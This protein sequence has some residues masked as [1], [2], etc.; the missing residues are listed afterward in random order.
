M[1]KKLLTALLLSVVPLTASANTWITDPGFQ[2]V[3]PSKDAGQS[4]QIQF[5]GITTF[6][7][8]TLSFMGIQANG[9]TTDWKDVFCSAGCDN[10]SLTYSPPDGTQFVF[11]LV[12]DGNIYYAGIEGF[13]GSAGATFDYDNTGRTLISFGTPLVYNDF[14]FT[15]R[16]VQQGALMPLSS[17]PEPETYAMLLAGLA[18][19][20]SVARRRKQ[21]MK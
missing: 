17:V 10:K 14:N 11:R 6:T 7:D 1:Q 2:Y 21:Q 15:L 5:H 8:Y 4:L 3:T 19:V 12:A 16:N 18:M 9:Y 13:T 20:G